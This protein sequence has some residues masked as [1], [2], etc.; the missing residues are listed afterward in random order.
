MTNIRKATLNLTIFLV[1]SVPLA[2]GQGTY[3]QIDEPDAVLGT[4]VQG[5]DTAGDIVG[6]YRDAG[7]AYHGFL[8]SGGVYTTI[9]YAGPQ[10]TELF[11]INDAGQIVGFT[12][13]PE[14]GFLYDMATQTF[15]EISFPG[16]TSTYALA[17][18]NSGTIAGYIIYSGAYHGFELVGSK[19]RQAVPPGTVDS[20]VYGVS[21][22]GE[23]AGFVRSTK[24]TQD[25]FL[26]ERGK[27]TQITIPNA[28]SAIVYG[29][30]PAGNA[31]VGQYT[32]VSGTVG[33]FLY[34]NKTLQ[35]LQF[36]GSSY[37][38]A[39]GVNAGGEVVGTFYDGSGLEHG[40]TWVSG[41]PSR[42]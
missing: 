12:F 31:L 15:T 38:Y 42:K 25:N 19:Y 36:P 35:S 39:T 14:I 17:I 16:S 8:L 33:G 28:P 20:Y 4:F 27:F 32:P 40:F 11:G 10:Y 29:I 23:L 34:Q 18:N 21:S 24:Q 5:V 26:F 30:N 22:S 2:L 6:S 1:A 41:D 37:T 3:T 7:G 13:L 9:D